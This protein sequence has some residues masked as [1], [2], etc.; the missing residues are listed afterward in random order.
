MKKY[1]SFFRLHFAIGLQY[2]AAA[3]A[4][5]ATQFFWGIM[6]IIIYC[7]FY[8]TDGAREFGKYPFGV[9]GKG[10]LRF[11]TFVIPYALVQYYPL[12]YLLGRSSDRLLI[13]TPL[14]A[15]LFLLPSYGLWRFG[16]HRYK[17]SGS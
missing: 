3:W 9:Y 10:I 7:T 14:A 4:G 13:F 11:C 12:L 15:L 16:V 8:R 1:V 17:S 5:I 6:E 2:R